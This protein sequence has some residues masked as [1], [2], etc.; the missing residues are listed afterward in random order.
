MNLD[1]QSLAAVAISF[2]AAAVLV[3]GFNF[4]PIGYAIPDQ[5]GSSNQA[6]VSTAT[7]T[8]VVDGDTIDV[9]IASSSDTVRLIGVDAPEITWPSDN[10]DLTNPEADECFALQARDYLQQRIKGNRVRVHYDNTQSARDTYD[11]RLSYVFLGDQLINRELIEGGYATVHMRNNQNLGSQRRWLES[12][13]EVFGV[14]VDK[15][16]LIF[17]RYLFFRDD[18][19]ACMKA[20]RSSGLRAVIILS[21][22]TTS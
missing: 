7:V 6:E 20:G 4:D 1:K 11:R 22:W 17:T 2:T 12:K 3:F 13:I 18:R 14:A 16:L 21:S 19:M 8:R 5:D 9:Q 15:Y 10:N